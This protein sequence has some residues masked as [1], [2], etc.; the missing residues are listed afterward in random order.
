MSQLTRGTSLPASRPVSSVPLP[1]PKQLLPAPVANSNPV[2]ILLPPNT[3]GMAKQRGRSNTSASGSICVQ[4]MPGSSSNRFR[5]ILPA[6]AS[7]PQQQGLFAAPMLQ[8]QQIFSVPISQQVP[9]LCH[10]TSIV[11]GPSFFIPAL[12]PHSVPGPY[13]FAHT[14][15]TSSAE[16]KALKSSRNRHNLCK[17]CGLPSLKSSGHSQ[18]RGYRFCP[19]NTES[20]TKE[21]WLERKRG[22]ARIRKNLFN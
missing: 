7:M 8:Q 2:E 22:E 5:P 11:P 17:T 13:T 6:G 15:S 9:S 1:A 16:S 4:S 21:D 19:Y 20:I 14:P 10:A 12:A 3:A 18:F